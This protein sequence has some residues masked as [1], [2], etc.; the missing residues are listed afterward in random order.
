MHNSFDSTNIVLPPDDNSDVP[1]HYSQPPH[2]LNDDTPSTETALAS[3]LSSSDDTAA[4]HDMPSFSIED[5]ADTF[6]EEV[7]K[8]DIDLGSSLSSD[9]GIAPSHGIPSI[10]SEHDE[11]VLFEETAPSKI[12]QASSISSNTDTNVFDEILPNIADNLEDVTATVED[13]RV[14]DTTWEAIPSNTIDWQNPS[15]TISD[16]EAEGTPFLH[17]QDESTI[18]ILSE[19]EECQHLLGHNTEKKEA[20]K[21]PTASIH[22]KVNKYTVRSRKLSA[23]IKKRALQSLVGFRDSYIALVENDDFFL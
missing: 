9:N 3:I 7:S 15:Q 16:V 17:Q 4:I 20:K 6:A 23:G 2:A 18:S 21:K 19:P 11:N 13:L 1:L 10:T 14:G 22:H 5:A 12:A 8:T